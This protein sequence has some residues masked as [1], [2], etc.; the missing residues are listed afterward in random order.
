MKYNRFKPNYPRLTLPREHANATTKAY[1]MPRDWSVHGGE[2]GSVSYKP[3]STA[4]RYSQRD[5]V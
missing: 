4:S 5:G 2:D 1:A 3:N